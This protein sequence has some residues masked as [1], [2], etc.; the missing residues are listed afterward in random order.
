MKKRIIEILSY[1]TVLLLF[2][3]NVIPVFGSSDPLT[4]G[5]FSTELMFLKDCPLV[6]QKERLIFDIQEFPQKSYKDK[7]AFFNYEGKVSAEYTLYNPTDKTVTATLAYP[8]GE[9]PSYGIIE[10]KLTKELEFYIDNDKFNVTV[11]DQEVD[12]TLRHT[13]ILHDGFA[14]SNLID[15]YIEDSFYSSDLPVTIY[16]FK[17]SNIKLNGQAALFTT[18]KAD[19]KESK[20]YSKAQSGRE[21]YKKADLFE[22]WIGN[23]ATF[24][25]IVFGKPLEEIPTWEVY[26]NGTRE[27][28]IEGKVTHIDT[29]TITFEEYV[30]ESYPENSNIAMQDWYNA[31]VTELKTNEEINGYIYPI[32]HSVLYSNLMRWYVYDVTLEPN[33]TLTTTITAPVYPSII[34]GDKYYTYEYTHL[35]SLTKK[36]N[37]YQSLEI[38]INTPF[39]LLD[40]LDQNGF[41]K[42]NDGYQLIFDG[43]YEK[44]I[45]FTITNYE[46]TPIKSNS[47]YILFNIIINI[48]IVIIIGGP[49]YLFIR[50]FWNNRLSTIKK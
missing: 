9:I 43:S 26:L 44:D 13:S 20:F 18:L 22:V 41:E 32:E 28:E 15:G 34:E 37:E 4:S 14:I 25:V 21:L 42:T 1:I 11:N 29:K 48:F 5:A 10:N 47:N 6:V 8:F 49:L 30:M 23:N 27:E 3:S 39:E 24:D 38:Q 17:T 12:K 19:E 2:V 45:S 40:E 31:V 7:Q 50:F 35:L 16:S 33:Q 36:W 46:K